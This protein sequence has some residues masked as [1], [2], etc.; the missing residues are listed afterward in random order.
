AVADRERVVVDAAALIAREDDD[1]LLALLGQ[2]VAAERERVTEPLAHVFAREVL[3][4]AMPARDELLSQTLIAD[5]ALERLR[6]AVRRLVGEEDARVAERLGDRARGVRDDRQ[7]GA[8]RLE[9]RDAE[10]LVIGQREKRRRAAVVRDELLGV[11]AT[12][13]GDVLC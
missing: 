1:V 7:V 4:P 12:G 13:E 11:D 8:H 2:L 3:E 9:E 5:G 10:A 6:D